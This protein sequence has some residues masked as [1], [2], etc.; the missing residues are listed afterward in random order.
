MLPNALGNAN[1][2]AWC[3]AGDAVSLAFSGSGVGRLQFGATIVDA[4][5]K[6]RSARGNVDRI[7][8]AFAEV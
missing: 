2:F 3:N 4:E 1:R 8:T 7:M 6:D 5:R